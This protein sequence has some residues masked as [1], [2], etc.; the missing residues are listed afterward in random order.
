VENVDSYEIQRDGDYINI[1]F[2]DIVED[3]E[4][5]RFPIKD[6]KSILLSLHRAIYFENS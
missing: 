2:Y 1:I 5:F 4:V 6:A 3:G